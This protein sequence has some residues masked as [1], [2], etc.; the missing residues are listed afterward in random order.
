MLFNNWG[1]TAS[2]WLEL[3][4]QQIV[5]FERRGA[6]G[7]GRLRFLKEDGGSGLERKWAEPVFDRRLWGQGQTTF[8]GAPAE[9][10]I[11]ENAFKLASEGTRAPVEWVT[12]LNARR[13]LDNRLAVIE[14]ATAAEIAMSQAIESRLSRIQPE[15]VSRI[16]MSANGAAGLVKLLDALDGRAGVSRNRVLSLLAEPRN[17]AVHKG[18]N[19]SSD[20]VDK[21]IKTSFDLLQEFSPLPGLE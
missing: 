7:Y 14:A 3:W 9:L 4:T 12:L 19:P 8:K 16:I 1:K 13:A 2:E 18:A 6:F 17:H 15:A 10:A 5:R 20:V 21:A 11:V